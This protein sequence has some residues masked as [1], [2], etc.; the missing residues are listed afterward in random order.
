[1]NFIFQ[2]LV[3]F[4]TGRYELR[5]QVLHFD[6]CIRDITCNSNNFPRSVPSIA[7]IAHAAAEEAAAW[8]PLTPDCVGDAVTQTSCGSRVCSAAVLT[9]Q[10]QWHFR[11]PVY[12]ATLRVSVRRCLA[13]IRIDC[14]CHL[15]PFPLPNITITIIRLQI[16]AV[17]SCPSP[18][19]RWGARNVISTAA[20][21]TAALQ[22]PWDVECGNVWGDEQRGRGPST[23]SAARKLIPL[24]NNLS[25]SGGFNNF[26]EVFSVLIMILT[27]GMPLILDTPSS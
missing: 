18:A 13:R 27:Y 11:H 17:E 9:L 19:E 3:P 6:D 16:L 12:M 22:Q 10:W 5:G 7:Q 23:S 8:N 15:S 26:A 20:C 25:L 21:S 24:P 4:R 14:S 2:A 1:M